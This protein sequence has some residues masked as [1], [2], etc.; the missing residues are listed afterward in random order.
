MTDIDIE[1][2]RRLT[3]EATPAPW[4]SSASSGT[5][6]GQAQIT[7]AG[8]CTVGTW[9]IVEEV[10]L[11]ANADLITAMRNALPDLLDALAAKDAEIKRLRDVADAARVVLFQSCGSDALASGWKATQTGALSYLASTLAAL[12]PEE[13]TGD[14]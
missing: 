8:Q 9:L 12:N 10:P 2:L 1:E 7:R 5:W 13:P 14:R 6:D 3:A 4:E 11:P